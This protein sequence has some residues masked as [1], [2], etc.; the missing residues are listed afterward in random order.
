L[1]AD[2]EAD[3]GEMPGD[4]RD[5]ADGSNQDGEEGGVPVVPQFTLC[6]D[7][8]GHIRALM[9]ALGE[10]PAARTEGQRTLRAFE[11][12]MDANSL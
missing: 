5:I 12:Y 6:A 9:A 4:P 10:L 11:L 3:Y 1:K 7:K 2:S 8:E